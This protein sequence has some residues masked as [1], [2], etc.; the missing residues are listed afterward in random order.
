MGY[1]ASQDQ[2]RG[3]ITPHI[4]YFSGL[5]IDSKKLKQL[6]ARI[7][8]LF[9]AI[10]IVPVL[11]KLVY[12][13]AWIKN[14]SRNRNYKKKN[15]IN[16]PPDYFLYETYKLDYRSYIEDGKQSAFEIMEWARK[17]NSREFQSILEWGCGVSRILRHLPEYMQYHAQIHGCDI[18]PAMIKW[19]M[20]H[21]DQVHY[22]LS[23]YSPPTAY[24]N[25]KFDMVYGIS[26]F[27]H[28]EGDIQNNWIREIHRILK[29]EGL[30][31][32]TTHGKKYFSQMLPNEI[33][34]LNENGYYARQYYKK[35]H[36]QMTTYNISRAFKE[37]IEPYFEILEFYDG[38]ENMNI[39]GGQDFW[40][41]RKR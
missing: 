18:N 34:Q 1:L 23:P 31:I 13:N 5:L 30:F 6:K 21:I 16:I 2:T 12:Y 7:K 4:S 22:S 3:G 28:I 24:G 37:Q 36:R 39:V 19:N 29:T 32:F 9:H 25:E 14:L 35:G 40:I 15:K 38:Q 33:F 8:N 41:V 17:H 27:T 20:E 11:D 26:V 10:G